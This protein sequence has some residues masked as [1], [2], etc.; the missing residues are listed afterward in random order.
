MYS[1]VDKYLP[2][3]I[4]NF[5][6]IKSD[7][8]KIM[9]SKHISSGIPTSDPKIWGPS[10]WFSLH[11]V[12]AHYP[13]QASPIVC[14]NMKNRI[15]A[16]PYEIPCEACRTHAFAF[17]DTNSKNLNEIVSGRHKLG[18]FFCDF[19]NKVNLRYGKPQMS[20]EDVYKMYSGNAE[21]QYIKYT[22]I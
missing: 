3:G 4:E 1:T 21:V 15:L 13:I 16:I 7:E 10:Y 14:E 12:A 8:S 11:T 20:Y 22:S 9:L 6:E 2:N 18:K 17:I 19:H 5:T